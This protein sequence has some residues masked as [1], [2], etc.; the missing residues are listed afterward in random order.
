[1]KKLLIIILTLCWLTACDD[2]DGPDDD[3]SGELV[4]QSLEAENDTM[5][6]GELNTVTAVASG[7][8][9]NY[10]W[11]SSAGD[12]MSTDMEGVVLY[13]PSPCHIGSNEITCKVT[14]GN[15]NSLTKSVC[16]VVE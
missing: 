7:Y 1:M 6:P 15:D 5:S 4:F 14:D 2:N 12:I 10:L 13:A 8:A 16:I 9:L 11:S 3:P